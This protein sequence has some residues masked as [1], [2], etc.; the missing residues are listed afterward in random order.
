MPTVATWW[1]EMS[2]HCL[3]IV[4]LFGN[5]EFYSGLQLADFAA[6]IIDL[7]HRRGY[8]HSTR[9]LPETPEETAYRAIVHRIRQMVTL[10]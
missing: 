4:P 5:S 8:V 10:P 2:S 6:H 7:A 9:R 3:W 1:S